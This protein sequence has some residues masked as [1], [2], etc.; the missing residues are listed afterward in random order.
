MG[1]RYKENQSNISDNES[2]KMKT[3]HGTIQGYN[4]QALVD[5]KHQIIVS[6]EALGQGSDSDL[7][8]P[9]L[10]QAIKN[11]KKLGESKNFFKDKKVIADTGYFFEN[12]LASESEMKLDA[13]IPDQYFRKRD[14]RFKDK[15]RFNPDKK[16]G[17]KREDFTYDSKI[18]CMICPNG[19]KLTLSKGIDKVK[20][21][22]YKKYIGK[23]SYC[24]K[25]PDRAKCL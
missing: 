13:Y 14:I 18:D 1:K 3:G 11:Y 6:A 25:C 22:T 7:L 10:G 23:K 20:N 4:G 8:V 17:F 2:T 9:I 21:F 16:K 12:N 19:N 5:D 15:N 24:S